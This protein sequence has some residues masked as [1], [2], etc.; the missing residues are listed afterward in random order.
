[1]LNEKPINENHL[2]QTT[3]LW[4]LW[5]NESVS[6]FWVE[7]TSKY[8]FLS[9]TWQ[10][11]NFNTFCRWQKYWNFVRD[12]DFENMADIE[13]S[14]YQS[15]LRNW[16]ILQSR[17]FSQKIFNIKMTITS[18]N[19][20]NLEK[21]IQQIKSI[22]NR[23]GQLYKKHHNR[24]SIV[25]VVLSEPIKVWPMRLIWTDL[26]ISFLS[27]DPFWKNQI[28]T[29]KFFENQTWPLDTTLIINDSDDKV[30]ITWIVQIGSVTGVIDRIELTLNDYT[31]SINHEIISWDI[32]E[33]DTKN[34]TV[35]VNSEKVFF[36]WE[37]EDFPIWIAGSVKMNYS[38]S[39]TIDSYNLYILYDKIVL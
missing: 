13:V 31:V 23:W 9:K 6:S 27:L 22:F 16:G 4:D 7:I 19:I 26:D 30:E 36:E 34:R 1:M 20:E 28:W 29:T 37:F 11:F 21:E 33:F 39:G 2:N 10:I 3:F 35:K 18:D 32:I 24:E 8:A 25:N 14:S 17:R 38:W 5:W 12:Q 15:P